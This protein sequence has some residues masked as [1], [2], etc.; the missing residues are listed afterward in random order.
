MITKREAGDYYWLINRYNVMFVE[1]K[2]RMSQYYSS[3]ITI[4]Q[5]FSVFYSVDVWPLAVEVGTQCLTSHRL[6]TTACV[7]RTKE[8]TNI[9]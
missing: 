4:S 7:S 8:N 1:N 2:N 9:P 6:S 5:L 3:N